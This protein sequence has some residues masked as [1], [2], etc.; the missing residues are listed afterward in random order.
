MFLS[1]EGD[2]LLWADGPTFHSGPEIG[3]LLNK[4]ET[5]FRVL[6]HLKFKLAYE[7]QPL[8]EW[9]GLVN[10]GGAAGSNVSDAN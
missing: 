1:T 6:L 2:L 4:A 8:S 5:G 7:T 10:A 9:L 3:K